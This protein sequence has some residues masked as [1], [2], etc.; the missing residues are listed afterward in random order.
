MR[1][2]SDFQPISFKQRALELALRVVPTRGNMGLTH[3][4]LD[5]IY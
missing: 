2:H 5:E 3:C 1:K 4:A